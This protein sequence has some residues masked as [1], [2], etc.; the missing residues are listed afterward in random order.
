MNLILQ[1][2]KSLFR[3][4]ENKIDRDIVN[5]RSDWEQN[6][7]NGAGYIKNR[8]HYA[9]D[10]IIFDITFEGSLNEPISLDYPLQI[11][12]SYTINFNENTY[13]RNL[14]D[15]S[16]IQTIGNAKLYRDFVGDL[17][18]K[19][20]G[21]PFC[22]AIFKDNLYK[23]YVLSTCSMNKLSIVGK[24]Y[25]TLDYKY[26]PNNIFTKCCSFSMGRKADTVI[27]DY[28]HAEGKNT[29][30]SEWASHAEGEE[31]IASG[32]TSHAEGL[33][34]TASGYISHA[35]GS[36][37]TASGYYSHAEGDHTTASG[38][39]SH[40]E[41]AYNKEKKDNIY[42]FTTRETVFKRTGYIY[43][44]KKFSFDEST[45]SFA[46]LEPILQIDSNDLVLYIDYATLSADGSITIMKGNS[47]RVDYP[48]KG[49]QY[50]ASL[51]NSANQNGYLHCIGNGTDNYRSNA[52]T[53]DYFGNAWYSGDVYVG[54]NSGTDKDEGSKKL[55]TEEYVSSFAHSQMHLTDKSTG[56]Q[57]TIFI[58]NGT[59]MSSP[60]IFTYAIT[61]KP[62][63]RTYIAGEYFDATGMQVAAIYEDESR[64][65]IT[66]YSF[67]TEHLT[68]GTT[69]ITINSNIFDNNYSATTP[70]TVNA[71]DPATYLA[72][73]TYTDN[74][75]G[76]YTVTGWADTTKTDE[77][78]IPNNYFVKI[79]G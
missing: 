10:G 65:I 39:N 35:E 17:E 42:G 33:H 16:S 46:L 75:D 8:T 63:T 23:A 60:R 15:Y 57:H 11:G 48:Y 30:A 56:F 45:G 29:T 76:T 67:P 50:K 59:L 3:K 18:L 52:H 68:E 58:D 71:L 13:K 54:S 38:S 6:D 19:D 77:L 32:Y 1:A 7:E 37:T 47:T 78:T 36:H 26:L 70:I 66:D 53:V 28:S 25:K 72:D 5:N 40:V 31:T 34:A 2:I 22:V 49:L 74:G 61:V 9:E 27:G 4:L 21:E 73:Y 79:G 14:V 69:E 12:T 41:G 64:T 24:N 62:T 44:S 20:T 55:A 51:K 43:I